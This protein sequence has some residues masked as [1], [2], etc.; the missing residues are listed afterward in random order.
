VYRED[1]ESIC[2][3]INVKLDLMDFIVF[4]MKKF[5]KSGGLNP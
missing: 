3:K 1:K 5:L 2:G 4:P